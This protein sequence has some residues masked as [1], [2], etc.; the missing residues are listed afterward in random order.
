MA[1]TRFLSLVALSSCPLLVLTAPASGQCSPDSPDTDCNANGI[2]D[3]CELSGLLTLRSGRLSPLDVT[4]PQTFTISNAPEAL[5]DLYIV[6]TAN[7]D[8]SN[9]TERIDVWINDTPMQ[10]IF[11]FSMDCMT[12]SQAFV[13]GRD[14]YNSAAASGSVSFGLVP[15]FDVDPGYCSDSFV[16]V[17]LEL[18]THAAADENGNGVP[19]ECEVDDEPMCEGMAP[20]VYVD[21]DGFVVG[22]PLDG[23]PYFGVLMGTAGD[24]VIMGTDGNDMIMGGGGND[25]V[26]GNGGNDHQAG[27]P[28]GASASQSN[29]GGNGKG[30]GR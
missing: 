7:A 12:T 2:P 23:R 22:G 27:R 20:T 26:C 1:R 28:A 8:L 17:A 30:R 16:E 9:W 18:M 13:L 10:S 15:S 6:F 19:D 11:L 24:D 3:A 29:A 25:T 4:S 5:D 14:L 21:G